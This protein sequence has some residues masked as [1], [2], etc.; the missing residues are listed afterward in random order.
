[1][2]VHLHP[3]ILIKLCLL[4]YV[5]GSVFGYRYAINYRSL[6]ILCCAVSM[7]PCIMCAC[8]RKYRTIAPCSDWSI[9]FLDTDTYTY[10]TNPLATPPMKHVVF[11]TR[12]ILCTWIVLRLL[13]TYR[14]PSTWSRTSS[15]ARVRH[16]VAE[17]LANRPELN[18]FWHRHC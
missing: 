5:S 12:G 2:L 10:R 7:R 16:T 11:C 8:S 14:C 17:T 3:S 15:Q 18:T 6:Y 13:L 9:S 4:S 1:M